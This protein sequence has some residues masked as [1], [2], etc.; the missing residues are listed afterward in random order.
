MKRY[1]MALALSSLLAAC[2]GGDNGTSSGSASSQTDTRV[3][4][5]SALAEPAA[6]SQPVVDGRSEYERRLDA[7]EAQ[8]KEAEDLAVDGPCQT[9]AQCG[10]LLFHEYGKCPTS[11]FYPYVLTSA[12]AQAAVVAAA[13]YNELAAY[14]QQIAPPSDNPIMCAAVMPPS[15]PRCVAGGCVIAEDS[16]LL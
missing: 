9:D 8:R 1:W 10:A 14:A 3:A 7:A 15:T 12:T 5:G 4:D 13:E 6:P 11:S 16:P 2:G